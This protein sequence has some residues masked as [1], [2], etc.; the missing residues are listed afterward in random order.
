M[1]IYSNKNL[2]GLVFDIIKYL[3]NTKVNNDE[4]GID[5]I[6]LSENVL[7][8]SMNKVYYVSEENPNLKLGKIPICIEDN[9]NM[10]EYFE[11]CDKNTL[12]LSMDSILCDYLYYGD[13]FK[14]DVVRKNVS[15]IFEKHGFYYEFGSSWY[16]F[17][18]PLGKV[19]VF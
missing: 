6:R 8:Y 9:V 10:E 13:V 16:I 4:F 12:S 15:D 17:A 5:K 3:Y 11:Y 2:E 7:I 18:V 14:A 19:N 1:D